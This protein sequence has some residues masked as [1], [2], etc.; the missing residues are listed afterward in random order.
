MNVYDFDKTVFYPD[1]S[2]C[3]FL[4]CLRR[5]PREVLRI[6]PA[7][8]KTAVHYKL[9]RIS[10]RDLKQQ[11]FSFLA[12]IPDTESLVNA[13]W[14]RYSPRI[15]Q[16]Y[17]RQKEPDDVIISASPDFLLCEK[18]EVS[19]IATDMDPLSGMIRGEN[20][21]D[22]EKPIRF[23]Q[24]YPDARI[25]AFYSDS[26]S[27]APMAELAE[28]AFLVKKNDIYPWPKQ[29]DSFVREENE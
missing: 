27:D 29:K 10:T 11:V 1:S 16:W 7:V 13:F 8:L 22:K 28:R 17:L 3:F 23:F 20:C 12:G 14:D 4:F 6:L 18:L 25:K 24:Q 2:V 5:F 26:L 19:L 15:A 9:K 21:H